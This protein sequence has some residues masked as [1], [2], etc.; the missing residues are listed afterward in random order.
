MTD[1][2]WVRA[3]RTSVAVLVLIW[4]AFRVFLVVAKPDTGTLRDLPRMLPDTIRLVTRLARDRTI[5]R[6]ARI[7]LWLLVGYL[8]LPIDLVPDFLPVIGYADDAIVTALVLRYVFRKAGTDKLAEHWP[9]TPE[10][11]TALRRLL[12]LVSE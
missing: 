4:V 1:A 12:R 8:G 11:L 9:G 3:A 10:G 7:P 6:S 5:S 2:V